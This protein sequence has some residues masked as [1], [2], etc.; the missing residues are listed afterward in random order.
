[1]ISPPL[2]QTLLLWRSHRGLTQATL[3]RQAGIPRPNLSAIEQGRREVTLGTLRAL[4]FGLG[5]QPGVLA[6]GVPPGAFERKSQKL[7]RAALER[8]A[9]AVVRGTPLP[10]ESEQVIAE[11][12]RK[13]TKHRLMAARKQKGRI[14]GGTREA[15]A[16]W[17]WLASSYPAEVLQSLL[18]RTA[19]RLWMR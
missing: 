15:E 13:V 17:L 16:A 1:M 12:L 6:D 19:D 2:G 10:N 3:A 4:A 18:Q 7:D 5:V 11:A 8:I 14:R 9:G